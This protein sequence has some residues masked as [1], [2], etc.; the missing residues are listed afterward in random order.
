V[1]AADMV[2]SFLFAEEHASVLGTEEL[3]G[4]IQSAGN[5][6]QAN[7]SSKLY[8]VKGPRKNWKGLKDHIETD[9]EATTSRKQS[10]LLKSRGLSTDSSGADW[11]EVGENLKHWAR[12]TWEYQKTEHKGKRWVGY[13]ILSFGT[14]STLKTTY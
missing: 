10:K 11:E 5:Y 3:D 1:N 8:L 4:W 13:S 14:I 2:N 6:Y 9:Y 7:K 12:Q